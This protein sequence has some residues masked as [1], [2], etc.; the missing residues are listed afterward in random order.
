MTV[1][2]EPTEMNAF[3]PALFGRFEPYPTPALDKLSPDQS[4]EAISTDKLQRLSAIVHSTDIWNSGRVSEDYLDK[5]H[6]L[7][8][9]LPTPHGGVIVRRGK[10]YE[11][12][13]NDN[14]NLV[15][16][17]EAIKGREDEDKKRSVGAKAIAN[18]KKA[19]RHT[20]PEGEIRFAID[21]IT[22]IRD[23][24]VGPES[25][26][27]TITIPHVSI[28]FANSFPGSDLTSDE[29]D[30]LLETNVGYR[31]KQ[32]SGEEGIEVRFA[33]AVENVLKNSGENALRVWHILKPYLKEFPS[34]LAEI[35]AAGELAGGD[36]LGLNK[37]TLDR[38]GKDGPAF[39]ARMA[40]RALAIN[41]AQTVQEDR[42]LSSI[43]LR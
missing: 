17:L 11:L 6:E 1:T 14:P 24:T 42:T 38:Y 20:D 10:N 34:L 28:N 16:A 35:D 13:V 37:F 31:R 15:G 32:P 41:I 4:I 43:D 7:L 21:E 8:H 2:T 26:D 3:Q 18:V 27:S 39:Q 22:K 5:A 25:A 29:I 19:F 9:S 40:L 33:L 23:K 30:A 36:I 12:I